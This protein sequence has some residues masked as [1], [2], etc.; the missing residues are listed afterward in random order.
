M[1][2]I[3]CP[4][5]KATISDDGQ[6]VFRRSPRIKRLDDL[7]EDNKDLKSRLDALEKNLEK[8]ANHA[9]KEDDEW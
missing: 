9:Q 5:C 7:I 6:K 4:S 1:A 3:E 8:G 2:N